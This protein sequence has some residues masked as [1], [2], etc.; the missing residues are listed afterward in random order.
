MADVTFCRFKEK[1]YFVLFV[2]KGFILPLNSRY[3]FDSLFLKR[4]P[5]VD[6]IQNYSRFG[7]FIAICIVEDPLNLDWRKLSA[8]RKRFKI[9]VNRFLAFTSSRIDE[10]IPG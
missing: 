4:E 5:A 3:L 1:R 6:A 2:I 8:D 10:L 7:C 9:R